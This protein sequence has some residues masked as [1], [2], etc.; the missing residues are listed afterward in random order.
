MPLAPITTLVD[1]LS[2]GAVISFPTDTVP[3][4]AVRPD[5]ADL[6]FQIKQRSPD[7]PLILLGASWTQLQPYV[8]GNKT[9][10][11]G[12]RSLAAQHWPGALTLVLS[13][14][15]Q[16]PLAM[17]PQTPQTIGLR[18]PQ[19]PLALAL[20]QQTGPLATSSANR[21][22]SVPLLTMAAIAAA[23]PTV[24]AL[25]HPSLMSDQAV[26]S[27]QPS[28]VVRWQASHWQVL[29]SG[30]VTIAATR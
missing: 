7:K 19:Q 10:L 3:A 11:D 2:Q 6:L 5:R 24:W 13:A 28:T 20:L 22:G 1:M 15:P 25:S 14:S 12:W 4:L 16:V 23:F 26:G 8:E 21:S 18:V 30:S 27:A 17:H 29:R 9:D